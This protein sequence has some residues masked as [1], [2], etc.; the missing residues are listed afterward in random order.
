MLENCD[1]LWSQ[2]RDA[3]NVPGTLRRKRPF[4][5]GI[6]MIHEAILLAE[7]FNVFQ[8]RVLRNVREW[9]LEDGVELVPTIYIHVQDVLSNLLVLLGFIQSSLVALGVANLRPFV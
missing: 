3:V 7:V 9:I 2:F 4:L 5:H 6:A 8:K 1:I